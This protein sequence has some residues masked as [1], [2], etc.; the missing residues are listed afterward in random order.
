MAG[1]GFDFNFHG[2]FSKKEDAVRKEREVGGFIR[3]T[4][5]ANGAIRYTVL[6]RKGSPL[7]G[8]TNLFR[9]K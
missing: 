4:R 5:S 2:S 3:E 6:T 9:R 1:R 8:L 7:H